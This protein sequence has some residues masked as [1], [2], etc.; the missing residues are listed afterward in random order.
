MPA[1]LC[2]VCHESLLRNACFPS[3]QAFPSAHFHSPCPTT[4]GICFCSRAMLG[5][6]LFGIYIK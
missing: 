6:C 1:L 4:L 2:V 5:Q 3:N